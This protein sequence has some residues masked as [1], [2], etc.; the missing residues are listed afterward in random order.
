MSAPVE[1]FGAE[2]EKTNRP[3][4]QSLSSRQDDTM[5]V[6]YGS[7]LR[8]WMWLRISSENDMVREQ[9]TPEEIERLEDER[10]ARIADEMEKIPERIIPQTSSGKGSENR[11]PCGRISWRLIPKDQRYLTNQDLQAGNSPEDGIRRLGISGCC[12]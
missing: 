10:D 11:I 12:S 3:A 1:T 6:E 7:G 4:N 2:V 5:T 8:V 9:L